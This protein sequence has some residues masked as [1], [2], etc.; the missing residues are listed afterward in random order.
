[1]NGDIATPDAHH[2]VL[3]THGHLLGLSSDHVGVFL[4]KFDDRHKG[5]QQLRNG[6]SV[7]AGELINRE[8]FSSLLILAEVI[9]DD[10]LGLFHLMR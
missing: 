6:G 8:L 7:Q 9:V 4:L 3:A 1:M 5:A 2:A 10:S